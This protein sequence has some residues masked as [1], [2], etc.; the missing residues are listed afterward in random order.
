[1][2]RAIGL[3]HRELHLREQPASPPLGDVAL[4]VGVG[5]GRG[6]AHRVETDLLG[7]PADVIGGHARIV[8]G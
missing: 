7:Q 4:R 3:R 2:T 6:H 5:L 8:H 1:M